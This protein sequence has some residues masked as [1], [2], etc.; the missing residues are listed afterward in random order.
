MKITILLSWICRIFLS[1][2]FFTSGLFKLYPVEFFEND[3]LIHRLGTESTIAF[4]ARLLIASELVI[5]AGILFFLWDK[6]FLRLS[7]IMLGVY[8]IY[9]LIILMVEGNSGNCGCFGNAIVLTPLQGIIKNVLFAVLTWILWKRP[10]IWPFR[11][12]KVFVAAI[13]LIGIATPFILNP[14]FFPTKVITT[15]GEKQLLPFE[16]IYENEYEAPPVW[17]VRQGKQV[18]GFLLL[19]CQH[20]RL[21]AARLDAIKRSHP[22][23]PMHL[24]LCGEDSE[25]AD[26]L[27]E[28]HL[29]TIEYHL[30]HSTPKFIKIAGPEFPAIYMVQDQAAIAKLGFYD[31]ESDVLLNW[32]NG[33]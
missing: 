22:E 14:I 2:A 1:A 19:G 18:V 26:F 3:L 31:I 28:T 13:T 33:Q 32:Y 25:L 23:L 4:E 15:Q 20:C 8:T 24:F 16:V 9:L 5:G 17:D 27:E 21:A 10:K 11:F 6:F 29:E 7:F 12:Q 30:F